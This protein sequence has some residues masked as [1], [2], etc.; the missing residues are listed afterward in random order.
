[1]QDGDRYGYLFLTLL[2]KIKTEDNVQYML[3]LVDDALAGSLAMRPFLG[4]GGA[5][6]GEIGWQHASV[7]VASCCMHICFFGVRAVSDH[8]ERVKLFTNTVSVDEAL[9]YGPLLKCLERDNSYITQKASSIITQLLWYSR[10]PGQGRVRARAL[11]LG[12]GTDERM[13]TATSPM[14]VGG[15]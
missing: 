12:P 6:G 13:T 11:R 9:P 14:A 4:R 8:P 5:G 1:M 3:T 15:R 7:D 10:P 2:T